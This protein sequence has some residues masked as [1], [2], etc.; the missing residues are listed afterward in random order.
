ML[1]AKI[2][3]LHRPYRVLFQQIVE[4][5][6]SGRYLLR[7]IVRQCFRLVVKFQYFR[8]NVATPL[9]VISYPALRVLPSCCIFSAMV[10]SCSYS[11]KLR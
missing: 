2:S 6:L 4:D 8:R 5:L 1:T 9:S 10:W 3:S 7:G 11:P